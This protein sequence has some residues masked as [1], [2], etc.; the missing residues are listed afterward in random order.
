MFNNYTHTFKRGKYYVGDPC[1]VVA[2]DNWMKLIDS[3]GCFGS[4]NY[5]NP[6]NWDHGKFTYNGADCYAHGTAEG[7]G[8][9]Q[10]NY[11]R[12]YGVDA[13]LIGVI[14]FVACDGDFLEGGNIVEFENDFIVYYDNGRFIFGNIIIDTNFDDYDYEEV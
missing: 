7:D 9:F 8:E 3:T 11:N 2:D 5:N 13:G 12:T 1:Y 6:P 14:P 10:D 4:E